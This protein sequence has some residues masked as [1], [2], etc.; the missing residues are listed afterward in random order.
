[1]DGG[2]L[3]NSG[4]ATIA[5]LWETVEGWVEAEN[6]L[7][8]TSCIVPYL[9]LIDSGYGPTPEPKSDQIRELLVP[10]T[11]WFAASDSRTIE[12][13]NDAALA[14]RRSVDGVAARD[15]VATLFLRSQPGGE[16]PLGWT[17]DDTTVSALEAQLFSNKEELDEIQGWFADENACSG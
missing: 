17:L 9:I 16:A 14:F 2:Y 15:R 12:G 1:V 13:R 7:S 11:G 3:D 10:P 4:G 8:T 5:E 6:S